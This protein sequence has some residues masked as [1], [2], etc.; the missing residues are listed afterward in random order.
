MTAQDWVYFIPAVSVLSL[1]AF[2]F[3]R[4]AIGS[5][6]GTSDMQKFAVAIKGGAESFLKRRYKTGLALLALLLPTFAYAQPEHAGGGE[7][8]LVLP[9]LTTVQF[10]RHERACPSD[11][12]I[13]FLRRR[14]VVRPGH[15]CAVEEL[16]GPSQHARNLRTDLRNLQN[17]SDHAGQVHHA[18]LGLHRGHHLAVLRM[19]GAGTRKIDRGYACRSSCCSRSSASR[20]ATAWRGSEF[21]S[22]PL[23]THAPRLPDCAAS[24]IRSWRFR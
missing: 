19:A 4:H 17:L 20:A 16:A 18:A 22:T 24:R 11:D 1:V 9:D 2:F 12:R 23:P 13:A 5:D 6:Q 7:A 10:F 21:A 14:P 8:N 15:L 3:A